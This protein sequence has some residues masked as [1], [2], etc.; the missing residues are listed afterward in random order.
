MSRKTLRVTLTPTTHTHLVCIHCGGFRC[1]LAVSCVPAGA[2]PPE[3]AAG[4]RCLRHAAATARA[5]RA[6]ARLARRAAPPESS[7][8]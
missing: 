4:R 1:E 6:T 2:A 5:V 7:P 3:P 8:S